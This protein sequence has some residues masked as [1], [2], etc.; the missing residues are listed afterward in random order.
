MVMNHAR[1]FVCFSDPMGVCVCERET[2]TIVR[3]KQVEKRL[4]FG[5][6]LKESDRFQ[7]TTRA[8][9]FRTENEVE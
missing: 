9:M 7:V 3:M 6:V 2:S 8:L 5:S 1:E 4:M